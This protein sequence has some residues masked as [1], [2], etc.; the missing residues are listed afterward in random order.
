M[1]NDFIF[2]CSLGK[3]GLSKN[4]IEGDKKTPKGIFR[5]GQLFYRKDRVKKPE[6]ILNCLQISKRMCWS[7]DC[8]NKKLYNRLFKFS[9]LVKHEKLFRKD[10]KYDYLIPILY[11]TEKREIGKGSAIF[12][13]L[14]KN[15]QGTAGC[16][17]VKKKDFLIL[18]KLI[19]KKTRIKIF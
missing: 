18:M 7:N 1:F 6:T 15:Y 11:N 8:N 12:I 19:N 3:K 5:L 17:A 4:K 9:K 2:K 13:H 10:Y 14:T 16:V